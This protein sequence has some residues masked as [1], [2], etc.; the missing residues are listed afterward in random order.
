M[1]KHNIFFD[2]KLKS[3]KLKFIKGFKTLKLQLF[4]LEFQVLIQKASLSK[5]IIFFKM[6]EF[7][8]SPYDNKI[9]IFSKSLNALST[10]EI[11][12][13]AD[14]TSNVENQKASHRLIGSDFTSV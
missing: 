8:K 7:E 13:Y 14:K 5:E 9:F 2:L 6:P 4:W 1:F 12:A 11:N 3:V 10:K